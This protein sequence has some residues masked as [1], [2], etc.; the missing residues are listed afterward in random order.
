M[1]DCTGHWRCTDA[2]EIL[3]NGDG[4]ED[5]ETKPCFHG[6]IF[7]ICN[8][9]MKKIFFSCIHQPFWWGGLEMCLFVKSVYQGNKECLCHML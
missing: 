5:S 8:Y 2:Q 1:L 6:I 3:E 7:N 9:I 4:D